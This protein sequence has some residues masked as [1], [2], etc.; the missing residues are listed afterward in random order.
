[1]NYKKFNLYIGWLVFL[2]A[3]IVFFITIEDTVS[4]WDCGEYITAAYK[5]E[6][7]HPPGAPLFMVLGRLFTF[8]ADPESVAVW[9]NRLSALSSSLTILFMFWSLTMLIRKITLRGKSIR[10]ELSSGDKIAILGSAAIG[11]LAYTFSESFWFSAV[12][13]EVYAMSSLFTAVIFWAI[14]KWDEEMMYIQGGLIP[15]GYSPDRW[16]LL[17]MFLLGLA[18]GVHLLGILV[19]P[20]IAYIIFFRYQPT[21]TP[22]GFILTGILSILVLGFIQV[23]VIPGSISLASTFEVAFVNALGMPF[24][25]GTIFFFALL[26]G[27]CVFLIRFARKKGYRIMYSS[28]MG[29]VLLLIGY[30]SFAVIVIRSNAN[31][32]LDENDP[33]NLVTLHAYLKREQYGSAPIMF[34]QQWN[35]TEND[36]NKWGD[37]APF[38]LRRFVVVK[39]VTELKAFEEES[40]ATEYSK[41]IKGSVVKDMYYESNASTRIEAV[42]TYRQAVFFPR[43]Y[44]NQDQQRITGYKNWSGYNGSEDKG[45]EIGKDGA[46]LPSSGEN[47]TFFAKYQ[48][49]WMYWRYFMWNYAGRQNDIQGHGSAM[50]GNWASGF[51]FIDDARIGDQGENGTFYTTENPSNNHFFFLPLILGFIGI[52]FHFY[53]AP[54]DA[55]SLL[56]AFLFTGLAIIVYLNPRP[57]EPRER[58][59]AYAGSFFF[60]AMWIGIGA[61]A[62]YD[63]FKSFDKRELLRGGIITAAGTILAL[64]LDAGSDVSL[65]TTV[66][67]LVMVAIGGGALVVMGMLR[68]VLHKDSQ[69]A[70]VAVLLCLVVPLIMAFQGWDDHDRSDKTTAHDVALNYLE[71]CEPN[72]ILF[73]NGDNDTF[74][75]W[76][77][78]E[79]EGVRTDVRVCNLSLMQ[80]DWYTNQMKMRAYESDPLPIEFT[81]DQI[82]MYSGNTDQVLFLNL[83]ELFSLK[84]KDDVIREVIKLRVEGSPETIGVAVDR[85]NSIVSSYLAGATVND[86]RATDRLVQLKIIFNKPLT[87]G[88]EIDDVFEKYRSGIEILTA[89]SNGLI[90]IPDQGL[91]ALQDALIDFESAWDYAN[92]ADAMDFTRNDNNFIMLEGGREVRIFPSTGFVVPVDA[93]NAFASGIITADEKE[94]CLEELRFNFEERGLTREQV[95]MLDIIG[96]NEWNRSIAFS[97]PGGSDVSIALYRRGYIK[98]NGMVFELSPLDAMDV[99]FNLTKMYDNLM[100]NYSFGQMSD[101]NVLTDY[102]AR[103]HTD[104]YR[105]HFLSLAEEFVSMA[106]TAESNND[107]VARGMTRDPRTGETLENVPAN[108]IA[109]YRQKAI[110]LINRSLEVMPAEV[111]IDYGE[112]TPANNP[113]D[114]YT[115]DGKQLQAYNDGVLHD[116]VTVLYMAGDHAGAEK[117]GTVVAN[118]LE[119]IIRY[120]EKSEVAIAA[121]SWNTKDLYATINAYIKL[122][123]S[124][125]EFGGESSELAMRTRVQVDYIFNTMFTSM[126]KRLKEIANANGESTRRGS[127]SGYYS[128]MMFELED[129]QRGMAIHFGLLDAAPQ[130]PPSMDPNGANM[131]SMEEM[132]QMMN[133]MQDSM[134]P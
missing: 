28:L 95:M 11:A 56:L 31:T 105:L 134:E 45:T 103:R 12:E 127:K 50:R 49:G 61:Y 60:F 4:L 21:V 98:Q 114:N 129:Y 101:P 116:Y 84:A 124:A 92:L 58:D 128:R 65:P 36:R 125:N 63:A 133:Q 19:I 75:L 117:L 6:V 89:A 87:A 20:A 55:F 68:K 8:F 104:Q 72:G 10:E 83:I 85:L 47:I 78:Q 90:G 106:Y 30:G 71:S 69:G 16:L 7:G 94:D 118:Q 70:I 2:I 53:R 74:P 41:T 23:G 51:S 131:P 34:G 3:T 73:T 115:V 91:N 59:Y 132:Q 48:V 40:R 96:N 9:I 100:T 64:I 24:Y 67:W 26:V 33:E 27:A 46:R 108:V 93:D 110:N 22:L 122:M 112:P 119:S 121:S 130:T 1:M 111:V 126:I 82:Q 80:T 18:I 14:L 13:G 29:L 66:A 107:M 79:V 120:F 54:K 15:K 97:S 37:L 81:E 43:M 42:P 113:R 25:S 123:S 5:L 39:G 35:S 88:R 38:Y 86:D 17:I 44:W 57:Y 76:Y 62:L 32:P 102:Y 99:R 52:I 77:M 109:E